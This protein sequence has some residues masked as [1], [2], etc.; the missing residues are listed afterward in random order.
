MCR[1]KLSKARQQVRFDSLLL[2]QFLFLSN[3]FF[4]IFLTHCLSLYSQICLK[5]KLIEA[6]VSAAIIDAETERQ[7][8]ILLQLKA[9]SIIGMFT[10]LSVIVL[11]MSL[12]ADIFYCMINAFQ[13]LT[14]S[15]TLPHNSTLIF[16]SSS[17]FLC[18]CIY[19]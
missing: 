15:I 6:N 18:V 11:K 17:F 19:I 10:T 1:R 14:I 12:A 2:F 3:V 5:R 7:S 9:A 8:I 13:V 4:F 16:S